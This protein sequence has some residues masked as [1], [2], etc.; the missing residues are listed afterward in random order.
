MRV[1]VIVHPNSKKPRVE[2][3]I[4]GQVNAYVS[5]PPLEGKANKATVE[6]LADYFKIRKNAIRLISGSKSRL[7]LFEISA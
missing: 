7:K 6:A 4:L 3:D 2:K 1:N 5:E